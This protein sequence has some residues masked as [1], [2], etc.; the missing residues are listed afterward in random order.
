MFY[1]VTIIGAGT[2]GSQIAAHLANVG[3]SCTLLDIVP[4]GAQG[5]DRSRISREAVERMRTARRSPF[6]VPENADNIRVGNIVDHSLS[7]ADAD[8]I[9]EAVAENL[10]VKREVHA[11]IEGCRKADAIV[12]SNTSGLSIARIAEQRSP[13]YTRRFFGAHFYNP[14]RQM[15][16]LEVIPSPDT[17]TGLL[18]NFETFVAKVLGKGIVRCKDTPNFIGNRIGIFAITTAIHLAAQEGLSLADADALSGLAIGRP[19]TG[20]FRLADLIGLDVLAEVAG[21]TA[22]I[23][24]G[25]T[26]LPNASVPN[27]VAHLV[28]NGQL[29][30]KAGGGFYRTQD[31]EVQSL[32]LESLSYEAAV[33]STTAVDKVRRIT[34][35]VERWNSL[36]ELLDERQLRFAR[37][38]LLLPLHYAAGRAEDIADDVVSIDRAMRWGYNWELGP[39]EWWDALGVDVVSDQLVAEGWDIPELVVQ[40][41]EA[42]PSTFYSNGSGHSFAS[43]SGLA[44]GFD[45]GDIRL[46]V[47]RGKGLTVETNDDASLVDMGGGIAC[48]EFHSK[49][50]IINRGTLDLMEKAPNSVQ[51]SFSGLVVGSNAPHFCVGMNLVEFHGEAASGDLEAIDRKLERLQN[52]C[53]G[54]FRAGFPVV[55]APS[56]LALGGGCEIVFGANHVV[57]DSETSIGLVEVK[58]GLIPAGGGTTEMVSRALQGIDADSPEAVRALIR[59]FDAIY[60]AS[61]PTSAHGARALGYLRPNDTV[62]FHPRHRLAL[63]ADQARQLAESFT[64][65]NNRSILALGKTGINALHSHIEAR[66]SSSA[67]SDYDVVVAQELAAV[68]SGGNNQAPAM[69]DDQ[70]FLDLERQAFLHLC[71]HQNTVDRIDHMLKTGKPLSN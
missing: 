42:E 56:G 27:A 13:D 7:I 63:A 18:E 55:A 23:E 38:C 50:N 8:W 58:V 1:N 35:P 66:R 36:V 2:M 62:T 17:D 22:Q 10:S 54:L 59:V 61:I 26:W 33:L 51:S 29:G 5:D 47:L 19:R 14:P 65:P 68:I 15:H 34:D 70:L 64:V 67:L 20:T 48:L 43:G 45:D 37:R 6:T 53:L 71:S 52:A 12:T 24:E 11:L 44:P 41:S 28:Q 30:D 49:M 46:N 21:T 25:S 31:G 40:R 57:A 16:L 3:L 60:D 9:V 39:F 4:E 69:V 32:N